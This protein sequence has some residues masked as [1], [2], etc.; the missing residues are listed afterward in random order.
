MELMT[1]FVTCTQSI[2][3]TLYK[4]AYLIVGENDQHQFHPAF[5]NAEY[6]LSSLSLSGQCIL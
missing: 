4:I 1:D 2:I 6:L 3:L 5:R